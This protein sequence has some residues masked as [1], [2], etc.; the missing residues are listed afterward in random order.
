M[1]TFLFT[2]LVRSISFDSLLSLLIGKTSFH[3]SRE[4]FFEFRDWDFVIIHTFELLSQLD[5]LVKRLL[6]F[7]LTLDL[8]SSF[9]DDLME[10]GHL[11][12]IHIEFHVMLSFGE[13][14]NKHT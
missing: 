4:S 7:D 8:D 5:S 1:N 13:G 11:F 14:R 10:I 12:P 6:L 9:F 3:V 2:Q